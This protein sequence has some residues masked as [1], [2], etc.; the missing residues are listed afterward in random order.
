MKENKG[1]YSTENIIT[2]S[3]EQIHYESADMPYYMIRSRGS[4]TLRTHVFHWHQD[5]EI[6]ISMEGSMTMQVGEHQYHIAEGNGLII[7]S[8]QIHGGTGGCSFDFLCIRLHPILLCVSEYIEKTFVSPFI[9]CKDIPA[10]PLS[11][12]N[13]W[14]REIITLVKELYMF[15]C[16]RADSLPLLVEA[17]AFKIWSLLSANIHI[18]R[19]TARSESTKMTTIKDMVGFVQEHY[20]EKLTLREIADAGNVSVSCC[21]TLFNQIIHK[22]P[23]AYLQA[24]RLYEAQKLLV[25][26]DMSINEIASE[27]GISGASYFTEIFH[28]EY[29]AVSKRISKKNKS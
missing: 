12:D 19:K 1:L 15:D 9:E 5:I 22:S 16:A 3:N 2:R 24:F 29:G 7:N 10:V 8:K 28:K 4:S 13:D 25:D 23:V 20:S 11:A 14:Q 27:T 21:N 18:T 17:Y 26:T 6:I